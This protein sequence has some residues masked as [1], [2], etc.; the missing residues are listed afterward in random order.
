MSVSSLS[1]LQEESNTE[2]Y[3]AGDQDTTLFLTTRS[4][5][6]LE[7]KPNFLHLSKTSFSKNQYKLWRKRK[8]K[9]PKQGRMGDHHVHPFTHSQPSKKNKERSGHEN[10]VISCILLIFHQT[11]TQIM[12]QL[13]RIGTMLLHRIRPTV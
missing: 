4:V 13:W 8:C 12:F 9:A 3:K 2:C 11:R 10:M 6:E 5:T 7:Q 1:G